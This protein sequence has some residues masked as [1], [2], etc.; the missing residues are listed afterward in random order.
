MSTMVSLDT[1][2]AISLQANSNHNVNTS[3]CLLCQLPCC[4]ILA[5]FLDI[6]WLRWL[7]INLYR[8]S[9]RSSKAQHDCL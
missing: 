8:S 9:Y 1:V 7:G 5:I 6:I 3:D 4:R 2:Q